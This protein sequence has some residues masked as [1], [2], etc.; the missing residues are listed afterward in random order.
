MAVVGIMHSLALHMHVAFFIL[1]IF[2]L[3]AS[4]HLSSPHLILI[5]LHLHL[6]GSSH[7]I[8]PHLDLSNVYFLG[9]KMKF[10]LV[11]SHLDLKCSISSI[12]YFHLI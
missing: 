7:Q 8:L 12:I 10:H 5:L 6:R 1:S 9:H 11:I 2:I 4:S 3:H